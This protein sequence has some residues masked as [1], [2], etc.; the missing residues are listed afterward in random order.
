MNSYAV[1]LRLACDEDHQQIRALHRDAFGAEEGEMIANLVEEMLGDPSAERVNSF[2][3][4]LDDRLVG[5]VLFT[6]VRFESDEKVTA[7][8]LAP[9][10]LPNA[11]LDLVCLDRL[12]RAIGLRPPSE[13]DR[14]V[15]AAGES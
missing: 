14:V 2:V 11:H 7:Q 1:Q 6:A 10:V 5:H 3:A 13:C 12:R 4:E 9:L 15:L 8:I